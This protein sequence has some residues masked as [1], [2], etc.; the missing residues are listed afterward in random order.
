MS[1]VIRTDPAELDIEEIIINLSR[2]STQAADQAVDEIEQTCNHLAR[3]PRTGRARG[4]LAPGLRS[5]ATR[6][7]Y[8][9]YFVPTDD[10]IVV[11]RVIHGSRRVDSSMFDL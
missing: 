5:K 4:D 6:S 7:G 2:R 3:F 8:V 11:Q 1:Q 10:G 9:I